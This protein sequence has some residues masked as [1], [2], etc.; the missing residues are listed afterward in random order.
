MIANLLR[1]GFCSLAL[2]LCVSAVNPVAASEPC[3]TYKKVVCYEQRTRYVTKCEPYTYKV[4]LYDHCGCPY[5]VTKT[6][7]REVQVA[8]TETVPVV[9][10]VK[11]TY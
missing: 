4:T 2:L 7:Y 9:K 6:G 3:V 11:V 1:A 5:T 10:Y 8:V